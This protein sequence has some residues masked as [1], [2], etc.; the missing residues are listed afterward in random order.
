MRERK[1]TISTMNESSSI[2]VKA[3]NFSI[4]LL[5]PC[6]SLMTSICMDITSYFIRLGN[7]SFNLRIA[8]P[9][10]EIAPFHRLLALP[11]YDL[12]LGQRRLDHNQ[13]RLYHVFV[14]NNTFTSPKNCCRFKT[15]SCNSDAAAE[16]CCSFFILNIFRFSNSLTMFASSS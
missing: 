1:L 13:I 6:V 11:S 12:S 4:T 9:R 8:F 7:C 3:T 16:A 5:S 15:G 14:C 2:W 10:C